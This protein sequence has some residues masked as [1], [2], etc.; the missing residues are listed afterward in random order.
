MPIRFKILIACLGF[1]VVT[2][3]LGLFLR[4]QQNRLGLLSMEVYDNALIGVSYVRKVQTN[5]VRL[6]AAER[7]GIAPGQAESRAR[8]DDLL[9][10]LDVAIERAISDKG[11]TAARKI[12]VNLL[13]LRDDPS[14]VLRLARMNEIDE[15]LETLV[16]KYTADGFIYRIR[17]ERLVE[18][19]DRWVMAAL[20][21][22]ILLA[23]ALTH[24]LG[25]SIVP[26]LN[27]AVG[28]AMAIADGRLDNKIEAKGKSETAR[29][30]GS[31]RI[32]QSSIA[33]SLRQGEALRE[34]EAAR[35]VATAQALDAAEA[36]NKA[37]SGFLA[38][39]SHEM[40]TP[41]NGV[42]G[43]TDVL[44]DTGLTSEQLKLASVV[45][46]CG[47]HL[48]HLINDV[49]DFSKLEA[50]AMEIECVA[51]DLPSM[52]TYA[53]DIVAPRAAAKSIDIESDI[54]SSVPQFVRSDP[55]RVRQ[56]VLNL[57]GNAVKFTERGSVMLRARAHATANGEVILRVAVVDTG[58]GI[59]AEHLDRL[60]LSFSQ[61]DASISRRYGGTG[62]GLAISKRLTERMGGTIGVESEPGAGSTFWFE[63]PVSVATADEVS[64]AARGIEPSHVEE[65]L[66]AIAS[67]KRPL[68]LLVVEDNATNLQVA[69][70]ALGK[71]GITPHIAGNGLEA[72]EAARRTAY[73]VIL[74][75]VHMPEMDGLTATRAIRKFNGPGSKVPIIALTANSFGEDIDNCRAA[76]M[77]GHVGK[78]FRAE[79]LVVAIGDAL[80]GTGKFKETPAIVAPAS[81]AAPDIDWKIIEAFRADSGEEMLRL[82]I[83]TYLADTAAK[84]DR[85]AKL[86]GGKDVSDEAIRLAHSLKSASAMAGAAALSQLAARVEK[87]L[88]QDAAAV[89]VDDA[90]GMKTHFANYRAALV[91]RGLA[92]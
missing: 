30:L 70:A 45:R 84:L 57:L 44:C 77:N 62:L 71:F 72:I 16:Q 41:L 36:A 9:A 11:G 48:L 26:P 5:F 18:T 10:D 37:K 83:D 1:L 12:R 6:V 87:A 28:I 79:E 14:E 46:N 43:M 29:L 66:A 22:A 58:I 32:M 85:L 59:A 8:F 53:M 24:V 82:L 68:R 33:E 56:V 69:K 38:M 61:T 89:G 75:D 86:V 73:D 21:L 39:M 63:L 20:A 76:G 78:P 60:F 19:T 23:V 65:A 81:A 27:R 74:M 90:A 91:G 54:D 92:A 40:R 34:V 80:R 35:L 13:A 64:N 3:A 2:I 25:Q 52:L 88:A 55:G 7:S 67:L 49:L 4:E 47:E 31:L 15:Q 51:F 17:T 42:I 50:Q